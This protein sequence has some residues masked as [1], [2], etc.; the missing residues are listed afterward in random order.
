MEIILA[1]AKI[2]K[3]ATQESGDTL[4]VIERPHGGVSAVLADGQRSGKGAKRISNM[5][6]RKAIALLADGVRDGAAARAAHDYLRTQRS[7][8]VSSTLNIVSVDM[9]TRTLVISRNSHCPV[10]AH[11]PAWS[12]PEMPGGWRV[13]D[14]PSEA[15]GIYARTRPAITELPLQL[16]TTIIVFTDGVWTAGERYGQTI[17]LQATMTRLMTGSCQQP[18][19][20]A[21][22]LLAEAIALD[23]GRPNDDMSLLILGIRPAEQDDQVRRMVVSLPL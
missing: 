3:Y 10:L 2:G 6:V 21:D 12:S 11:N 8:Q 22:C 17:D 23:R 14:E 20:L 1:V 4:E 19:R 7:G 13:L 16:G 9:D 15:I 5:V 18:Q